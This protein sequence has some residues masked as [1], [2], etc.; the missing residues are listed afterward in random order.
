MKGRFSN[1]WIKIEEDVIILIRLSNFF[2]YHHR[3]HNII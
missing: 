2:F 1:R 3:G